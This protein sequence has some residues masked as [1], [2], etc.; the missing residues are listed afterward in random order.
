MKFIPIA[1]RS[2]LIVEVGEWVLQEAC[3]QMTAWQAA[4]L[5]EF[6][7]AVNL[8]MVQFRRG[9]IEE[10]VDAALKTHGLKPGCLELELTESELI[11]DSEKFIETL[12]ALKALGIRLSIDDFGTGYSNLSY[13]Q[14]FDVD[15]LKIDQSFVRR[16]NASPH[17][18][19]SCR[20]SSRWRTAW[21]CPPP[22]RASRTSPPTPSCVNWAATRAR[23]TCLPGHSRRCSSRPTCVNC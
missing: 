5:P 15:K 1:E 4:G 9:N 16:L 18:W 21:A 8:S 13:L 3:R 7:L 19:P 11:Q 12:Q 10:V 14:R 17:D 23:V 2:G 6:V 22:P 20:P